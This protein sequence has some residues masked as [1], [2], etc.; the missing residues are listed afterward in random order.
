MK[1]QMEIRLTGRLCHINQSVQFSSKDILQ[2]Y[3]NYPW[4][5]GGNCKLS[6]FIKPI[7]GHSSGCFAF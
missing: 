3:T 7:M 5:F 1:E 4:G 2:N 6:S